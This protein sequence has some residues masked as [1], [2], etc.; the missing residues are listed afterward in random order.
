MKKP[1][2]IGILFLLLGVIAFAYE[3]ITYKPG[4]SHLP[5]SPVLGIAAFAVGAVLVIV[6]RRKRPVF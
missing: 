6:G 4:T 5:L 1:V 2:V 3:G